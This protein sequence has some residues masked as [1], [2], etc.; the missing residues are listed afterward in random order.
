MRR[1]KKGR[2]EG[3]A[4]D[5]FQRHNVVDAAGL[6]FVQNRKGLSVEVLDHGVR[7]FFRAEFNQ[8]QI[9]SIVRT[10][11]VRR[12]LF[13]CCCIMIARRARI[14]VPCSASV[15]VGFQALLLGVMFRR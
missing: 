1:C 13:V 10:L 12:T 4:V 3:N 6:G 11:L 8:D 5:A 15:L 2:H 14:N 9:G 7:G